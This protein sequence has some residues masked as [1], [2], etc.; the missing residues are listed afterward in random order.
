M[1]HLCDR[2]KV[3]ATPHDRPA[4]TYAFPDKKRYELACYKNKL[5]EYKEGI[6][7]DTDNVLQIDRIFVNVNKGEYASKAD[8]AKSYP[9]LK[10]KAIVKEILDHGDFQVGEQERHAQIDRIRNEVIHIVAGRLV[11]PETK[12]VYTPGMIEKA[13]D[14]LSS[15]ATQ[16]KTEKSEEVEGD[17]AKALPQWRG[18]VPN[19]PVK[20][21]AQAA[22]KA[23]IAHQPLA[24][25]RARMR[26]K[27]SCA[28]SI[29]KR[30][31][32]TASREPPAKSAA[33]GKKGQ[34]GKKVEE[35]EE[36]VDEHAPRTIKETLLGFF[37]EIESQEVVGDEWEALGFVDP[38]EYKPLLEFIGAH[39]KGRG[40]VEILDMAVKHED[41]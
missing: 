19:K 14:T 18:V 27:V 22:T 23:L 20:T 39:T 34:K 30:A 26:V 41:D 32:E 9:G 38:G 5:L 31:P 17:Q 29:T 3:E 35:A 6:E 1:W 24:V 16:Q 2:R 8:L 36:T 37:T 12:R 28:A 11:N 21:Q 4:T 40:Q 15:Q 7:T 25:I 10:E 33:K 13:L